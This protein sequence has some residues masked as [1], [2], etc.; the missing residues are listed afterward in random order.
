MLNNTVSKKWGMNNMKKEQVVQTPKRR[1]SFDH[2]EKY[3]AGVVLKRVLKYAWKSK[4]LILISLLFLLCFTYLELYQPKLINSVLDDHLL[5]VQT[6]WVK[7]DDE[8]V[9][10][11]G[12]NYLKID[13]EN[14]VDYNEFDIISIVYCDNGYFVLN[15]IYKSSEVLEYDEETK[16]YTITN[17]WLTASIS[18]ESYED[19][20]YELVLT[21][22]KNTTGKS[23]TLYVGGMDM[24]H[25][26][27]MEVTQK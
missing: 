3:T 24:N 2:Y 27:S 20:K 22:V 26:D 7:T 14:S 5:G 16:T 18:E 11:L 17:D 10:Y 9:N 12:N 6:T 23:R 13:I 21:A 8:G 19:G 1:K 25:Q 4:W 15:G